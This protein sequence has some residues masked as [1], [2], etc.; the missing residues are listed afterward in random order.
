M[1]KADGNTKVR[2]IGCL[3]TVIL[4]SLASGAS[5]AYE[6]FTENYQVFVGDL[7]SDGLSDLYIK[8]GHGFK[9]VI[10]NG[11]YVGAGRS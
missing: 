3:F 9:W 7:N 2:L 6:G 8:A 10:T 11:F 1:R 5:G 4:A